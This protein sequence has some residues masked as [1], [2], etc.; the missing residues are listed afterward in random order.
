MLFAFVLILLVIGTVLFHI[1]SPW[2][3]TPL[4]SNWGNLD[5]ALIITF[6]ITGVVFVALNLFMAYCVWKYRYNKDRRAE[7]EPENTKLEI[8]LTVFTTIGVVGMLAPGLLAWLDYITVPD[9]AEVVEVIGEQWNWSF[10]FPGPDGILG[11]TD[12]RFF[13]VDNTFGLNP[14]DPYAKD[15]IVIQE[16]ELHLPID[17][18]YKVLLRSKDVLHDFYVPQFRAKMDMVPG[19]VTYL[20]F[21][22]TRTG[23]YEI[24]C[25]E[26]CGRQHS[27]MRGFVV[28]E[29]DADFQAWLGDQL[30]G[31]DILANASSVQ[32]ETTY[33]TAETK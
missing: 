6:W 21:T 33:K 16:N 2:W 10:R 29:E 22:P 15:D 28:I 7:Y 3:F 32:D 17:Q 8:W 11:T 31:A 12:A 20:W 4:A 27:E 30:T 23:T 25:A 18:P 13:N 19:L 5:E 14:E 9:D 26:Y 1:F 24:I